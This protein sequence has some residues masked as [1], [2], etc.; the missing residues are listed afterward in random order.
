MTYLESQVLSERGARFVSEQKKNSFRN[1]KTLAGCKDPAAPPPPVSAPT[2]PS[3]ANGSICKYMIISFPHKYLS[4]YK[5]FKIP[6]Y[7]RHSFPGLSRFTIYTSVNS[8]FIYTQIS[9]F[10]ANI[11]I[12][13]VGSC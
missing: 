11:F 8:S 4:I 1:Q 5:V 7:S 10:G 13:L 3:H 12:S 2:R 9:R 6:I